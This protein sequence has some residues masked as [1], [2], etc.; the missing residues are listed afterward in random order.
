MATVLLK[1][2]LSTEEI[3]QILINGYPNYIFIKKN[4]FLIECTT[5]LAGKFNVSINGS[6]IVVVPKVNG[7]IALIAIIS[8]IGIFI[9]IASSKNPTAV[10]LANYIKD[11]IDNTVKVN[12][13]SIHIPDTCPTCKNPNSKLI[14]LCEWCGSQ[15]C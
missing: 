15:I 8:I 2:Q 1:K 10:E 5:G 9:I 14:R 12:Q 11:N 6:Q 3:L 7:I 13:K 4:P